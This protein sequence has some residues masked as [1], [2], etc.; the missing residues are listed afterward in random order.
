MTP[1]GRFSTRSPGPPF[2]F[3]KDPDEPADKAPFTWLVIPK[4]GVVEVQ[5]QVGNRTVLGLRVSPEGPQIKDFRAEIITDSGD[6]LEQRAK[7]TWIVSHSSG[8]GSDDTSSVR[9]QVYYSNDDGATWILVQSGLRESSAEVDLT[10]LPGGRRCL[11]RVSTTD[12]F[13]SSYRIGR[14]LSVADKPPSC[15]RIAPRSGKTYREGSG[16]LLIGR[17][18]DVEEGILPIERMAWVSDAQG[19]LGREQKLVVRNLRLGTHRI[20]LQ[21]SD[22]SGNEGRS[23]PLDITIVPR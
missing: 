18:V 11:F 17:C 10:K 22:S 7:L 13:N 20:T 21:G 2:F 8:N 15:V 12:G 6:P 19:V 14:H 23:A 16:V 9:H 5:L 3:S 4:K 1:L